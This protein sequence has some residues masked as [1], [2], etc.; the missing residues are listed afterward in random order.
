MALITTAP[1]GAHLTWVLTV[2]RA[3][4][5]L[6]SEVAIITVVLPEHGH[7]HN[8]AE[9]PLLAILYRQEGSIVQNQKSKTLPPPWKHRLILIK[10]LHLNLADGAALIEL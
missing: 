2:I 9:I 8:L 6:Y 4:S 7:W 3:Q 5:T 1:C 10:T